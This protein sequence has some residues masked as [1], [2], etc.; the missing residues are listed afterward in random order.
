VLK[1][2]ALVF[3]FAGTGGFVCGYGVREWISY[4]RRKEAL[5][6]ARRESSGRR[7]D[8]Q[9]SALGSQIADTTSEI[10]A[11]RD[12]TRSELTAIR[13]LLERKSQLAEPSEKAVAPSPASGRP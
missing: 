2:L 11:F 5:N 10:K 6:L 13:G 4:R 9:M 7:R 3:L 8:P 12:E 1:L